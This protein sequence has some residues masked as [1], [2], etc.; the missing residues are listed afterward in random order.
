MDPPRLP[1]AWHQLFAIMIRASRRPNF[2]IISL[3]LAAAFAMASVLSYQN[4]SCDYRFSKMFDA[5]TVGTL[6]FG[7]WRSFHLRFFKPE[8]TSVARFI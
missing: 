4:V 6:A 3:F 2:M 8:K 1:L 5:L 7:F